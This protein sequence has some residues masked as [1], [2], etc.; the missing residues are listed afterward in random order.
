MPSMTS[1]T[2]KSSS[3]SS[4]DSD[5]L[6]P[7]AVAGLPIV[8]F[9]VVIADPA[10]DGRW[11]NNSAHF[12]LVLLAAAVSVAL[13][14]AV[15]VAARRRYDARLFLVSLAFIA[16]AAF[17]GLH[18]LAT[19]SVLLGK[20]AGFELATPVGLVIA[21]AFA[22]ASGLEFGPQRSAQLMRAAV[23]VLA[24]LG[25]LVG[26]W[27][28]VSLAGVRPL[29]N[30]IGGEELDGWQVGL[31]AAGVVLYAAAAVGYFRLFRRRGGRFLLVVTFAFALLAEAMVVI[32]WARNWHVSWWEWHLL[33]LGAF[34]AIGLSAR[35]EWYEERF[36][37]LYLE[38]T[39]AGARDVSILF[40]DLEGFTSY[41]ER[42]D[43]TVVA[44]MLNAYF[45]RLVPLLEQTGGE[46]HQLIGDEIMAV[47][48]KNG[49]Q[50]DHALRA[51]RA[52]LVLQSAAAEIATGHDRWPRF[53]VGINSGEA[54]TG[55]VG[56]ARGHRKHGVVGDTVNLAA[57]LQGKAPVGRVV[58]GAET[59]RRLPEG[60]VLERLPALQ[61]KGKEAP[62]EAYIV[63]SL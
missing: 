12:W 21:G 29:D 18:A 32:V 42:T 48:N 38:R 5:V 1:R 6:I 51:V 53:R 40:A 59:V 31:A 16:A 62:V 4:S 33:M 27:A 43:P 41:A 2:A 10:I 26:I 57:R 13:G 22:S 14:Y 17:L 11:E 36:S 52:G 7:A 28:A 61:V 50:P 44:A 3:A 60:A 35:S 47:F 15:S 20:N 8:L 45:G 34:V 24:G 23:P 9:V 19:P 55:V 58:L 39:L 63:Y 25:V 46:V 30:P 56:A 37:A 49:D 54:H